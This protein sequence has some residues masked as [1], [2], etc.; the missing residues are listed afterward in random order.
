M[1]NLEQLISFILKEMFSVPSLS[2]YGML[3]YTLYY[4]SI[5]DILINLLI[6]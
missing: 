5:E 3:V 2:M 4:I 1:V 6:L